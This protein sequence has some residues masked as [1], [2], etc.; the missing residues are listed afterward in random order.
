VMSAVS[1]ETSSA[2]R[3]RGAS[4]GFSSERF[5]GNCRLDPLTRVDPQGHHV[6]V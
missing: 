4:I 3:P 5:F 6:I 2:V 1:R